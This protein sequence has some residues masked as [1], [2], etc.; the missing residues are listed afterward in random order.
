MSQAEKAALWRELKD[1]G[2]EFDHH[3]REYTS[4]QL[5]AAVGKLR[6]SRAVEP[7]PVPEGESGPEIR[8]PG[9]AGEPRPAQPDTIAGLRL[10]TV[11][12]DEPIR[13]DE[14]GFIWYQDEVRKPSFPKPRGRRI[15]K[16]MDTGVREVTI[17]NGQF[18]ETFEMPGE[19]IARPAEAKITLPS[20]QTGIYKDPRF[21][22][23]IHV[24]N[25]RRGFDLFEVQDFYGGPDL[26]PSEIKRMYVES[27]LCYDMRTT[28]RAIQNEYRERVLPKETIP[29]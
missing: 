7:A 8:L 2:V 19:G 26:V 11:D 16:Y 1:A 21:P 29:R 13:V 27:S 9:A 4:D 23:K 25:E 22:F 15:L 14:N 3:Y 17:T 24:Y 5:A 6:A 18:T 10:N 12:T 20:Y 28:I